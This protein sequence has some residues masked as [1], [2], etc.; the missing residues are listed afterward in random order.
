MGNQYNQNA[1]RKTIKVISKRAKI[2]KRVYPYLLRHS[3]ATNMVKRGANI[4]YI[5]E[6]FRHAWIETTMLYI[7]SIGNLDRVEQYFPQYI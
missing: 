2:E 1:L 6:H 3:L 7:H 5:K 4:L